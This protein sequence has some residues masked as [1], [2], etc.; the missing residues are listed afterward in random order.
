M[1]EQVYRVAQIGI[2]STVGTGV[3]A[4]IPWA[5]DAATP[6]MERGSAF[7]NEDYGRSI[8]NHASRGYNG[9]RAASMPFSCDVTFEQLMILL[10]SHYAGGISPTGAGPYVWV[11]PFEGGAST[12]KSMTVEE[13]VLGSTQDEWEMVGSII[14]ELTIEYD[15]LAAPGAQPWRASGTL[16]ALNRAVATMT[17][18]LT[19]PSLETVMGHLTIL[20]EG[21]TATAFSSLSELAAS[22]IRFS[23]TT[24]RSNVRRAYGAASGD[25]ASGY[26]QS[27]KATGTF[28]AMVKVSAS[29]KTDLLD[30]WNAS[31]GS[32]GERRWRIEAVGS[33]TKKL[34]LDMRTAFMNV[35]I[36][37]RDGER[38]YAVSGELVD[39]STLSAPVQATI[40][41]DVATRAAAFGA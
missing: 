29:S 34:Q 14:D 9:L 4:T 35:G 32:L 27:E 31:G 39:D 26:G 15:A 11:Y 12:R 21:T 18:A 41:N 25:V 33:G 22:L 19:M 16:L 17:A 24:N 40:T 1:A 23:L 37:D 8:R 20:K 7:G 10:E 3:A 2:E 30:I 38:V 6:E 36:D 28:E 13:G 5:V